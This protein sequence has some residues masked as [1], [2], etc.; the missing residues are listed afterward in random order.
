MAGDRGALERVYVGDLSLNWGGEA[1]RAIVAAG[2]PLPDAL[3][4]GNDL[5]ALGAM[6]QLRWAGI[7]IPE[8]ISVTGIDDTPFGRVSDPELTTVRQP[9]DQ[10]GD[11]AVAMLLSRRRDP[12][13]A[14]R[15]LTLSPELIIRRSSIPAGYEDPARLAGS[16]TPV[17]MPATQRTETRPAVE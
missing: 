12:T 2:R 13:R 3:I 10:I 16:S 14:P 8:D 4:C 9:V 7:R 5:I 1:V 15:R 6:Q 17:T 11:E